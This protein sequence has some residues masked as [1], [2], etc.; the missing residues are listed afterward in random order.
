[1]AASASIPG[2]PNKKNES[3][4]QASHDEHPVLTF[5]AKEGKLL[6]QKLHRF[7]PQICAGLAPYLC[8]IGILVTKIYYFFMFGDR[9]PPVET[10]ISQARPGL[11][12]GRG[13]GQLNYW[14]TC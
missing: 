14:R 2:L 12:P 7:R 11:R 10:A 5:E 4:D 3:S 8:R 9:R 13:Q 6:D 1:L